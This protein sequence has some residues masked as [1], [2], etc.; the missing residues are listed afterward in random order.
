VFVHVE[1]GPEVPVVM[2][3]ATRG[4]VAASR[5]AIA[6]RRS[7]EHAELVARHFLHDRARLP[8]PEREIEVGH[9]RLSAGA[10]EPDQVGG[11]DVKVRRQEVAN[12]RKCA[13][14]CRAWPEPCISSS[15]SFPGVPPS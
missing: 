3:A 2:T 14:D 15:G 10:A 1:S 5:N 7:A 13:A 8:D 4:S 6:R 11:K 12:E 9:R